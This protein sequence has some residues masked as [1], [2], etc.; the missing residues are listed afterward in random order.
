[1]TRRLQQ[2][3]AAHSPHATGKN[4]EENSPTPRRNTKESK[5]ATQKAQTSQCNSN[6]QANTTRA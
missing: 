6:Q 1:M 5:N 2:T 4:Q 3:E